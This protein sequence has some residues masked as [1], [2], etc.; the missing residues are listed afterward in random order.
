MDKSLFSLKPSVKDSL[1]KVIKGKNRVLKVKMPKKPK[2][3]VKKD[4]VV[5]VKLPP[6]KERKL[7]EAQK[8]A[9]KKGQMALARRRKR[10]LEEMRKERKSKK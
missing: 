2:K 5:K 4:K 1:R 6:K 10:K 3:V 8:R 9:L 7:S